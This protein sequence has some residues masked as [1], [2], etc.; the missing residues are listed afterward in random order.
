MGFAVVHVYGLTETYGPITFCQVQPNWAD[1]DPGQ[2]ATLQARQG[3]GMITAAG[4]RVV[5][6]QMAD[7]P[8]DG[9]T[10][11]DYTVH[12]PTMIPPSLAA[13]TT[14]LC[15]PRFRDGSICRPTAARNG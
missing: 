6:E 5:D 12:G 8:A 3:V 9:T 1:L 10:M 11:V 7:V 2:R 13:P 15:E 4:V 14:V